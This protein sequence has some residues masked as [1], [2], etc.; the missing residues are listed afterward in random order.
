MREGKKLKKAYMCKRERECVCVREKE[1]MKEKK[2]K[3][4]EITNRDT[5]INMELTK[6]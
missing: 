6:T 5:E 2:K 1:M 3:G 4:V